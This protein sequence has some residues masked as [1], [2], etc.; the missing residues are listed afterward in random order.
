MQMYLCRFIF[1]LSTRAG[2]LGI[3]LAT[4]DIVILY[5]SDWNPQMDL[6]VGVLLLLLLLQVEGAWVDCRLCLLVSLA[7]LAFLVELSLTLVAV[8][9]WPHMASAA[10]S[11]WGGTQDTQ[12][13]PTPHIY[14]TAIYQATHSLVLAACCCC[15]SVHVCPRRPWTVRIAS[16]RRRRCR[17]SASAQKTASRRR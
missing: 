4:A 8:D 15:P 16:A 17:S 10:T 5:D 3:N 6:Q 14:P 7:M 9:C 1:L 11:L 12:P 2:G 13:H